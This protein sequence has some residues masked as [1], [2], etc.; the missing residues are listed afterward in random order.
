MAKTKVLVVDDSAFMRKVISDMIAQDASLE[1]IGTAR[2]GLDALEKIP[3]LKPDVVTLDIEMPRKDGL[4]TLRDVMQSHPVPVVMLS[5]MTQTG[6]QATLEALALGAIDF[7]AK[8]S[9]PI[10]LDIEKVQDELIRKIKAAALARMHP[11]KR[12]KEDPVPFK[13]RLA[14]APVP[15]GGIS[16]RPT[17]SDLA[18]TAPAFERPWVG[19]R[20][21]RPDVV[22]AIGS[23]TGG[24]RALETVIGGFPPD[25]S[26]AV[27]VVQHMPAEFTRSMAERLDQICRIKVKEAEEGDRISAGVV[28]VAPGD[29][30]MVVSPDGIIRLNQAPPVNYVRP[31]VDV[32]LLSLPAVYSNQLVGVILTGMGKDGAAG[33]AK[34]KA[35]GGVTIVQDERTSV[36]YSMPRAVVENGDADYILPLDR[37]GDAAVQAV[38]KLQQR[39]GK[40]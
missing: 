16:P 37:I 12:V 31:S 36:I 9:G 33:M 35:G 22:I 3:E 14:S 7:V 2:D 4:E 23:S 40:K 15:P 30:H 34:I 28:Y 6:A 1:V 21:L 24:P 10:S 38:T 27:L 26:A 32:T 8:P 20:G 18:G 17:V 11:P 25:L 5:S 39:V 19:A 29:Y 13:A